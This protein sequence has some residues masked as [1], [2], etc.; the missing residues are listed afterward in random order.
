MNIGFFQGLVFAAAI[1]MLNVPA[2]IQ[3]SGRK[4]AEA[5]CLALS[6]T[7]LACSAAT[8][9]NYYGMLYAKAADTDAA[10]WAAAVPVT[11]PTVTDNFKP[12]AGSG[13]FEP[14][15][16]ER[17][18]ALFSVNPDTVGWLRVPGTSID[19]AVVQ[20]KDNNY[21][22]R[23]DFYK[24]YTE[25]GNVFLDYRC[26][27][28]AL[29]LNTILY[30]H[31]TMSKGQAF[32][33]LVKYKDQSFFIKNPVVEYGTLYK[34]Y[35]WKVFAV[36]LTAADAADDNGYFFNYIF[37]NTSPEKMKGYLEQVRQRVFYHTGVE[38]KPGENILTLSTC[39]YD[40]DSRGNKI[41]TRLVVAA[42]LL[43]AGESETVDPAT[44]KA[45][46]NYRRPQVWYDRRGLKNPFAGSEKWTAN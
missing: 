32:Y 35:R 14:G 16:L 15:M 33:D 40:Y 19:T 5:A 13:A 1:Y 24:K 39:S 6:L 8:V 10:T 7:I 46:P 41:D 9:Y 34:N 37:V 26:G 17:Y 18:K 23:N 29:S 31:T 27:P 38:V 44:V 11:E 12:A 25:Y 22:L 30:G 20:S 42:R 36:F 43:R 28:R 3:R 21:Y 4:I 2:S 45:N